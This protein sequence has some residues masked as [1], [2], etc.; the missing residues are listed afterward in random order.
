MQNQILEINELYRL[1][2]KDLEKCALVAA[3]AFMDDPTSHFLL[4]SKLS[5]KSLYEYY[6]VIYKAI[7]EKTHIFADCED[8]NGFIIVAPINHF[9]ISHWDFIK[10][11]GLKVILSLG[12]G[13][14]LRSLTYDRNC[15]NLRKNI[16]SSADWY[17]FQ[18]GVSPNAQGKGVGSKIIKPF[19]NWLDTKN[20]ACYLETQ[21]NVNVEIYDHLGFDLK[22]VDM[23][24]DKQVN[25]YAMLRD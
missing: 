12:F 9:E 7:Y 22:S 24:P 4:S 2:R 15:I 16:V 10:F 6:F 11:G 25:Q 13:L 5:Q 3:K 1:K 19:L 17:I 8:I 20:L 21:K 23:M 18:F 14:V